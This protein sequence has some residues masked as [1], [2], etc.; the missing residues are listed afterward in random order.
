LAVLQLD[1]QAGFSGDT[2]AVRAGGRELVRREGVSTDYSLGRADSA[3]V[4]VPPGPFELEIT[5]PSRKLSTRVRLDA[6]ATPYVGVSVSASGE[7]IEHT[8][9]ITPFEYF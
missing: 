6:E 1:L 3:R 7:R 4:E 2:V 8:A 5:V 9:S